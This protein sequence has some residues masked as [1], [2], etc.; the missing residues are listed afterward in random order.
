MKPASTAEICRY[1]LQCQGWRQIGAF[2]L[3]MPPAMTIPGMPADWGVEIWRK[4]Y[5]L[6]LPPAYPRAQQPPRYLIFAGPHGGPW[7]AFV[8]LDEEADFLR[9][10]RE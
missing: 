9:H 6:S 2:S 4:E 1:R 7:S 10:I 5:P 8:Q 3:N